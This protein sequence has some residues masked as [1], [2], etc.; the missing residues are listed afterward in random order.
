MGVHR[1]EQSLDILL[2]RRDMLRAL[3]IKLKDAAGLTVE[4]ADVC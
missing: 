3:R 1:T 4:K 2:C